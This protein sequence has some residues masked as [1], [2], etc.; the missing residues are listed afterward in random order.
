MEQYLTVSTLA[1][2][3]QTSESYW[4]K[5]ITRRAL[6]IVR[7]GGGRNVRV[8]LADAE[9]FLAEGFRPAREAQR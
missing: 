4:R 6:P 1:E 8:K 5:A 2:R 7:I 9:R 3:T